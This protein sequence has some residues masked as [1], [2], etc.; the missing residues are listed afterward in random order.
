[1]ARPEAV[2]SRRQRTRAR[3]S[4]GSAV[5]DP[6]QGR[7]SLK[8]LE[9]RLAAVR[10]REGKGSGRRS[11]AADSSGMGVGLKIAVEIVAAIAVGI[12]LGLALDAW[13][14]TKPWLMLLFFFLGIAAAF[15]NVIRVAREMEERRKAEKRAAADGGAD[16]PA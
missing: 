15:M 3:Q 16:G 7:S 5:T 12:G 4:E 6:D 13:L 9:K 10:A 2:Q 1:M 11:R 8:A 14:G